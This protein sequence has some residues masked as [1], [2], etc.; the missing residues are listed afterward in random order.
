VLAGGGSTRMGEPKAL[1]D[2]EGSPLVV[3]VA[4]VVAAAAAPVVVVGAPGQELPSLPAG[5]EIARDAVADQ[6]PLEGLAAG[7][8]AIGDRAEAAFVCGADM[9]FLSAEAVGQ[10]ASALDASCDAVV[11]VGSEGRDQPLGAI[12]RLSLLALVDELLAAGERRLGLVAERARTHRI[13]G[14]GDLL[15][16]LRSVNT[17]EDLAQARIEAFWRKFVEATGIDGDHTA[18]GFGSDPEMLTEL[19]LLVRDGPKRATASLKSAYEPGEQLP[20]VGDLSVILDG[21]GAPLC[22]IRIT[23]VET[24]RF[25]DVDEEFAWTEAEGDRSLAHWRRA[26]IEFFAS[27][28]ADVTDDDEVVLERFE[29]LWAGPG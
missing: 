13:D 10:L 3:H 8:R 15:T 17:P 18:W 7:M 14:D 11:V 4:R 16:A 2:W 6:G 29:L 22:V 24:R 26:H 20:A 19:G 12:Y 23:D 27:H 5:V 28:G 21:A 1:L 9:P 25:G